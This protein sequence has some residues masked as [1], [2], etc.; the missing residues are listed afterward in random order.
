MNEPHKA[1][2][3]ASETIPKEFLKVGS[4]TARRVLIGADSAP[5]FA[6]RLFT[7]EPGG[8]MPKHTNTVEHEQFVVRG[9]ATIGIG[10]DV[11]NVK[12]GDVVFI[13]G[14]VPHWYAA[15]G[16]EPFEFLC[17]VPNLP[18]EITICEDP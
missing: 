3:A 10:E 1:I 2:V 17:V 18:D 5:N 15:E 11:H 12:K 6:M 16:D 7:I 8:A 14:G 4:G 13:P 9:K